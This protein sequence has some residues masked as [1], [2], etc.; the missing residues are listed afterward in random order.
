MIQNSVL[1][2]DECRSL[3]ERNP[4][5]GGLGSQFLAT[6]NLGSLES[7]LEGEETNG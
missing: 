7:I 1:N 5:P 6:R 2:P 3:E 4:I